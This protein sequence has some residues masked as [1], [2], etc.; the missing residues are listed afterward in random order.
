MSERVQRFINA[1][2]TL[3][4]YRGRTAEEIGQNIQEVFR[5]GDMERTSRLT[6][7]LAT[8][9]AY[10]G[11]SIEEITQN[12][13]DV[14]SM[15]SMSQP[16]LERP[17]TT[18]E[19]ASSLNVNLRPSELQSARWD[20]QEARQNNE[21]ENLI[22]ADPVE[23]RSTPASRFVD[24]RLP[25]QT[26]AAW[27]GL[28]NLVSNTARAG[29]LELGRDVQGART[30]M[31]DD[32]QETY[33][34]GQIISRKMTA[35]RIKDRELTP[36]QRNDLYYYRQRKNAVESDR[37]GKEV[38][39]PML[40]E[41]AEKVDKA[42][43]VGAEEAEMEA[44]DWLL[45]K[46]AWYPQNWH[47]TIDAA[48]TTAS[49]SAPYLLLSRAPGGVGAALIAIPETGSFIQ[50]AHAAGLDDDDIIRGLAPIY[51]I[52][53]GFIE[54]RA[55]DVLLAPLQS[56]LKGRRVGGLASN[57]ILKDTK[58]KILKRALA[59][60]GDWAL[61]V[62]EGFL[63]N[64]L[65]QTS[66]SLIMNG[67][68]YTG[69]LEAEKRHP[70]KAD[71]YRR[72]REQITLSGAIEESLK[73]GFVAGVS[74]GF[75]RGAIGTVGAVQSA[76]GRTQA[77]GNKNLGNFG[78]TYEEFFNK[79]TEEQANIFRQLS[80]E[81]Q[82]QTMWEDTRAQ[83]SHS[84]TA[85]KEAPVQTETQ[86]PKFEQEQT[87]SP[88][89][90]LTEQ[91][92]EQQPTVPVESSVLESTPIPIK[93]SRHEPANEALRPLYEK[94]KQKTEA[95]PK[96]IVTP[97][98]KLLS[99][100]TNPEYREALQNLISDNL[101]GE[102]GVEKFKRVDDAVK[103]LVNRGIPFVYER[104]DGG[105]LGGLN[106]HH[107]NVHADADAD[108]KKVWGE[109]YADAVRAFGGII[110]RDQGD[111]FMA[112]WPNRTLG[113]V[114]EIR[115]T[116]EIEMRKRVKE[117]GID[118]LTHGKNGLPGVG[119]LH[120]AYGLV[121]Y[122]GQHF[123]ELDR[124]ADERMNKMK[125][126]DYLEIANKSGYTLNKETDRYEQRALFDE[127][128]N[129]PET[130]GE[131]DTETSPSTAI[132]QRDDRGTNRPRESGNHGTSETDSRGSGRISATGTTQQLESS[133]QNPPKYNMLSAEAD[134][135]PGTEGRLPVSDIHIDPA[136]F[137]FKQDGIDPKRGVDGSLDGLPW[138]ETAAG[139]LLVWRDPED[140]KVYVINGHHRLDR[141]KQLGV[142]DVSVRF[143][144]A[145]NAHDALV[146]GAITNIQE[147]KGSA[148]DAAKIF[149]S[150]NMAPEQL[151]EFG[152]SLK[153]GLAD[154]GMALANLNDALFHRVV[155]GR[156]SEEYAVVIGKSGLSHE[157]QLEFANQI[158]DA[159]KGKPLSKNEVATA[160]QLFQMTPVIEET[161][162][163][164]FGEE[165]FKKALV[166]EMAQVI[167]EV[168]KRLNS[169]KRLGNIVA[170]RGE[171]IKEKGLGE[172]DTQ[173]GQELASAAGFISEMYNSELK[174]GGGVT[175]EALMRGARMVSEGKSVNEAVNA[176]MGDVK[177][178][179]DDKV[180]GI[181]G[182]RSSTIN[183]QKQNLESKKQ[184][185]EQ[186]ET[187]EKKIETVSSSPVTQ[188]QNNHNIKEQSEYPLLN[189]TDKQLEALSKNEFMEHLNNIPDE[190]FD[191]LPE[192][193]VDRILDAKINKEA[194]SKTKDA[195][196]RAD[197]YLDDMYEP[198]DNAS[199]KKKKSHEEKEPKAHPWKQHDSKPLTSKKNKPTTEIND[200]MESIARDFEAIRETGGFGPEESMG[201]KFGSVEEVKNTYGNVAK[202]LKQIGNETE[203]RYVEGIGYAGESAII[204]DW[205]KHARIN[206][207]GH[208]ADS[209]T[210][211]AQLFS[212]FRHPRLE[213][214]H[215]VYVDKNGKILAHNAISSGLANAS[216]VFNTN[217]VGKGMYEINDRMKRLNAAGFYMIHNHPSGNITASEYDL[218]LAKEFINRWRNKGAKGKFLGNIILDHDK[219]AFISPKLNRNTESYDI[220]GISFRT[221]MIGR[222]PV[223][224]HAVAANLAA[225]II[226]GDT[227]TAI[228]VVDNYTR[229]VAWYP[230]SRN[231]AL[232]SVNIH[233][234]VQQ[235]GGVY[236]LVVTDNKDAFDTAVEA[237]KK[238][239]GKVFD[240]VFDVIMLDSQNGIP[241]S[242][243]KT[244]HN[245][246]SPGHIDAK[247]DKSPN[248]YVWEGEDKPPYNQSINKADATTESEQTELS[249]DDKRAEL[250]RSKT[251]RTIEPKPTVEETQV[252]LNKIEKKRSALSR[253]L[254]SLGDP[255]DPKVKAE[256]LKF[257]G[258]PESAAE[259]RAK[260]ELMLKD[261]NEEM[262]GKLRSAISDYARGRKVSSPALYKRVV[263]M[264]K[265][266]NKADDY[267]KAI[268]II[269]SYADSW[270]RRE[271]SQNI[272][273][274]VKA[275]HNRLKL[276]EGGKR[277]ST[278][279]Y[280]YNIAA[281]EYIENLFGPIERDTNL[282]LNYFVQNVK[283][284]KG[285]HDEGTHAL[286][287]DTRDWIDGK[288]H[289]AAP[290]KVTNELIA[291]CKPTLKDMSIERL[292]E[293]LADL[294]SLQKEGRTAKQTQDAAAQRVIEHKAK[295]VTASINKQSKNKKMSPAEVAD[296]RSNNH[297]LTKGEKREGKLAGYFWSILD[298]EHI[299]Q[300]MAGSVN[301]SE[302]KSILFDPMYYA[303][304]NRLI[305]DK[306]ALQDFKERFG[307]LDM[308]K[309]CHDVFAKAE[310][311]TSEGTKSRNFTLEEMMKVYAMSQNDVQYHHLQATFMNPNESGGVTDKQIEFANSQIQSL[312]DALPQEYKD[313]VE[314]QWKAFESQHG[315]INNVYKEVHGIDMPKEAFYHPLIDLQRSSK[316]SH[317][318]A[319]MLGRG[320]ARTSLMPQQNFT[321]SRTGSKAAMGNWKYFNDIIDHNLAVS[322]Y[323]TFELPLKDARR[324]MNHESVSEA[325]KRFSPEARKQLLEWYD[326]MAAN[327]VNYKQADG[328]VGNLVREASKAV[329]M[330]QLGFKLSSMLMQTTSITKGL[331]RPSKK[332]ALK[333]AVRMMRHPKK[334]FKEIGE[335]SPFMAT[336]SESFEQLI[337]EE[338]DSRRKEKLLGSK[339]DKDNRD[340]TIKL[341]DKSGRIYG[342]YS[343]AAMAGM[344][345]L[346]K[347][348]A[349][350]CWGAEYGDAISRGLSVEEAIYRADE[351]VRK[352]QQSGHTLSAIGI[353]RQGEYSRAFTMFRSDFIKGYNQMVE[354]IDAWNNGEFSTDQA[355]DILGLIGA[356]VIAH[357][358]GSWSLPRLDDWE[359]MAFSVQQ[360]ITSGAPVVGAGADLVTMILLDYAREWRG[361]PASGEMAYK[362]AVSSALLPP[363]ANVGESAGDAITALLRKRDLKSAAW[364]VS[365]MGL[366]AA[367]TYKRARDNWEL[368]DA[369][370]K[371]KYMFLT[372]RAS[373]DE[374][375]RVRKAERNRSERLNAW[376]ERRKKKW[377]EEKLQ[378][379]EIW[380]D[381]KRE[382]G[383]EKRTAARG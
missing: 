212:V 195:G 54:K 101:L 11:R 248:R 301:R 323:T 253:Y 23:I 95:I 166:S 370:G 7:A 156:L 307:K 8:L 273:K 66:E 300:K 202:E 181:T 280:E 320:D 259:A 358:V 189:M 287:N 231:S 341:K 316:S 140:N 312:I 196:K 12:V 293:I 98:E 243:Y 24:N 242:A 310:V 179:I 27:N 14:F 219:Y 335:L 2:S 3:D 39:V 41:F 117:L 148:L 237:T 246:G 136:R 99:D 15:S 123:G 13:R 218:N 52:A 32:Q 64:G 239:R 145:K 68:L 347:Y 274:E 112:V 343:R 108:I 30:P 88:E 92:I 105:N 215:Y 281:K 247:F 367:A 353:Q 261:Y 134:M 71:Y 256:I 36:A 297:D 291:K 184:S 178:A 49:A 165:S 124:L 352:T 240:R 187:A 160:A 147:G 373:Q 210:A 121:E 249:L 65:Q 290:E 90:N 382:K 348:I 230:V 315:K 318:A 175:T 153:K 356:G 40:Y 289:G 350:L 365:M 38:V 144:D 368:A 131:R 126:G 285:N 17:F 109:I 149:R 363:A 366:P 176:I 349:G 361:V 374:F 16:K 244:V 72:M 222:N 238:V 107:K 168:K 328:A 180:N 245:W 47:K 110:G 229:P 209:P 142:K 234:K 44:R 294:K 50:A 313:L 302:T 79:S 51:G 163:T 67:L 20:A 89:T 154:Q 330:A 1:A 161:Q 379:Y 359:D 264:M 282:K 340:I 311:E 29:A 337:A 191:T 96:D 80:P 362:R 346:D 378:E 31:D 152:V 73:E 169:D 260:A 271:V 226:N 33:N 376:A 25:K 336:R 192:N 171:Q 106:T 103:A 125:S 254:K 43:L 332:Q 86:I 82:D 146:Q 207:T 57:L 141:A 288:T 250:K 35:H 329:A 183:N 321:Q 120:T 74:G 383:R 116:V 355:K 114:E 286:N 306:E 199:K 263:T 84:R 276:L 206:L 380:L 197:K 327:R 194:E 338:A 299:I 122:N 60:A 267:R 118:K 354:V 56:L 143:I 83:V 85:P 216:K 339:N 309:V 46:E 100:I 162:M 22:Y 305:G 279:T 104:A 213:H 198:E 266:A 270:N 21:N 133:L 119:A 201:I 211:L 292:N 269:D 59:S 97:I 137:Q 377:S 164:L 45:K 255:E 369:T 205:K 172:V 223:G 170:K 128:R 204:G 283:D 87:L 275:I 252:D 55:D 227:H 48:S 342:S 371:A 34:R 9:P 228:V 93:V 6:G 37:L 233:Q 360:S 4:A 94:H 324:I 113:E 208:T 127:T 232:H 319:D 236:A 185:Q 135:K 296:S 69:L 334:Y 157:Q 18:P 351:N 61:S 325:M 167:E 257:E 129:R 357:I 225:K 111:E 200:G 70:E 159:R 258:M 91:A 186:T 62:G 19:P 63:I 344:A 75:T 295:V 214:V 322:H 158:I 284:I 155:N 265:N 224:S 345:M 278:Q 132:G 217:D 381:F 5:S 203:T 193:M 78:L 10:K 190:V 26:G 326:S 268:T 81:A 333:T 277:R 220:G 372:K 42:K 375:E 308:R 262:G 77:A 177:A 139:T 173:A 221:K 241:L 314:S 303:F 115:G 138:N 188:V 76:R 182:K 53:T 364:G 331:A 304:K 130:T 298:A 151:K 272:I 317:I 28:V 58:Q 102:H 150:E 235:A 174:N 251:T